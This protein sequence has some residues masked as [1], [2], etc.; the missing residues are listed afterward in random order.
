MYAAALSPI[1][2][3]SAFKR[4]GIFLY[5]PSV[6]SK[7]ATAPSLSF[8]SPEPAATQGLFASAPIDPAP[9]STH[10]TDDQV[11]RSFLEMRGGEILKNVQVAKVRKT[12]SKVVSGKA[13]IEDNITEKIKTHNE[14]SM[15]INR[16]KKIP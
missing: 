10:A 9:E 14:S 15:P 8:I 4:C 2:I 1:N 5:N 12:L 6:I 3:Q 7:T 16:K 11:A 13:I